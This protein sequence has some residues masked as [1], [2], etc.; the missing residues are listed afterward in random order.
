MFLRH[1][2]VP[3]LA[4]A[5]SSLL[6]AAPLPAHPRLLFPSSEETLVAK[7]IT[8]DPLAAQLQKTF[9]P[10]PML[11]SKSAPAASKNMMVNA[12]CRNPD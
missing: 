2:H 8:T 1:L 11:R 10:A 7:K 9:S 12:C 3:M 5:F 6:D 4:I